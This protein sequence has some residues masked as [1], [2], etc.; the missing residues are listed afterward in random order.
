[1]V[2]WF[3]LVTGTQFAPVDKRR[4]HLFSTALEHNLNPDQAINFVPCSEKMID[5]EPIE[6]STVLGFSCYVCL[7]L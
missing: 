4:I 7:R 6:S 5:D 2:E 3:V 1:M